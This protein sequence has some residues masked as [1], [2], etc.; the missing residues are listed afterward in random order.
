MP[1]GDA[2][3]PPVDAAAVVPVVAVWKEVADTA[4]AAVPFDIAGLGIED[5]RWPRVDLERLPWDRHLERACRSWMDLECQQNLLLHH[6]H[7][8]FAFLRSYQILDTWTA[9]IQ[10]FA[11]VGFLVPIQ[12]VVVVGPSGQ[13][14]PLLEIV[15]TDPLM[16]VRPVRHRLEAFVQLGADRPLDREP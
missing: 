3:V 14:A 8:Y 11:L 4:S 9:W 16:V 15:G 7:H 13:M 1:V 2:A 10:S 5:C 12:L 6:H